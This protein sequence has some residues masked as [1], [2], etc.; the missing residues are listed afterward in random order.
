VIVHQAF[1]LI[2]F[3]LLDTIGVIVDVNP[4]EERTTPPSKVD[5]LS[6]HLKDISYNI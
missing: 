5:M 6:I 4:I 3:L 2:I 1:F